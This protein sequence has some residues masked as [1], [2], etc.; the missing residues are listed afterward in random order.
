MYLFYADES[1]NLDI[2]NPNSWLYVLTA[3]GI[4]EHNWRNFYMPLVAHKRQLM[5]QIYLRSGQRL[6][7]HQC[8][9][10]STWLRIPKRRE[11]ESAFLTALEPSE[12]TDLATHYY[13]QLESSKAVCISVAI[14]KRELHNHFDQPKLHLK[15]WELLCERVE[16]YMRE[17]H[18]K[19]RAVLIADDVSPQENKSLA[20]KHAYFLE[21][22]TSAN[23]PIRRIVEMP[24]FVR[25]ELSEGV[26]LADL[27]AY[28]LY[29]SICYNKPNYP[30]FTR[31]LPFYYNSGNTPL[32]K[33]DG[34][35]V[36]PD[37]SHDLAT[38]LAN[39][40]GQPSH[41]SGS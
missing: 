25:S 37:V 10:K 5:A 1:G 30:Y 27:C 38:W 36:F 9:V 15:A 26:Q 13:N 33:L 12:R 11:A 41:S 23:L 8:E 20:N 40:K 28:S 7:L 17:H 31:L 35:K 14:D 16:H 4:F 34:L 32:H 19:H 18:P 6:G 2:N 24:L 22:R 3:V 39:I 21:Q 29:H